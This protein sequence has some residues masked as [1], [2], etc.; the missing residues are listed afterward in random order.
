MGYSTRNVPRIIQCGSDEAGYVCLPRGLFDSLIDLV[1]ASG[2]AYHIDDERQNGIDCDFKFLGE[3][4]E[5]QKKAASTMLGHNYGI[6]GAAT[7][8]GKSVIGTFLIAQKRT[9]TLVLVHTREIMNGWVANIQEFL[10]IRVNM[11]ASE[12]CLKKKSSQTVGK[13][14]AG[15]DSLTGVIDVA[16][17]SSLGKKDEIDERIKQYGMV[18]VDECHHA[19]A[20]THEDVIRQINARTLYGLTAT[21]K[22]RDG[23]EQKMFMQFGPIRYRL[24]ARERALTQ[25]FHHYVIPRFASLVSSSNTPWSIQE[26]Y[27][28][29]ASNERR[30]ELIAGDVVDCVS[31]GRTPMVLTKY[32]AHADELVRLLEK[33]IQHVVLLKGG[34]TNKQRKQVIE[35][36][37][38]IPK[39]ENLVVVAI[40]QYVG[41]GFDYPRLDTLMLAAP[42]AWEGIV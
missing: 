3:L 31:R 11:D 4:S 21:P 17:I 41:E 18:I 9:N 38:H 27:Q 2:I 13:L 32:R 19:S 10:D 22:R 39:D 8:F 34:R 35:S 23:L 28:Q 14:Y 5:A 15:H 36:L 40:G 37:W 29:I 42:V 30:N 33:R 7:G 20:P 1:D 6:L 12:G 16:M 25:G 26:A 24:T